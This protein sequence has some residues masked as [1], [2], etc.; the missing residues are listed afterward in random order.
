MI[1]VTGAGYD[2]VGEFR[3]S[4]DMKV[5]RSEPYA[6]FSWEGSSVMIQSW[7]KQKASG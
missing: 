5:S 4:G 2:P 1:E 7:K 3:G 6:N